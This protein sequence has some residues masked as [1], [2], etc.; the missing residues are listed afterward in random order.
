MEGEIGVEFSDTRIECFMD[1][2]AE[3]HGS[4]KVYWI[5]QYSLNIYEISDRIE[6]EIAG[7][8]HDPDY[9][10]VPVATTEN[11]RIYGEDKWPSSGRLLIQ[12]SDLLRSFSD[13]R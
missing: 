2:Y 7:T 12:G 9:G 8:Y 13:F 5:N 3:D 1:F 10:F 4:G 6:F 11:F